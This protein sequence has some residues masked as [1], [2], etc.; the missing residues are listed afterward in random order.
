M[1]ALCAALSLPLFSASAQVGHLPDKS[2]YEDFKI[3]QT[4]TIMGG[5]MNMRRDPANVA[6]DASWYAG[7]FAQ[8]PG[9]PAWAG[10]IDGTPS[11]AAT[12]SRSEI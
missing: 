4:L 10:S 1:A 7:S 11:I 8:S 2:P 5:W 12:R 6:P 3:G 9:T